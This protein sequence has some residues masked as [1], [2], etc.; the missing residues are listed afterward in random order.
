MKAKGFKM[1]KN[2][3]LL[4]YLLFFL[5]FLSGI[6]WLILHYFFAKETDFTT[7]PSPNEARTLAIHGLIAPFFIFVLGVIYPT[8]MS[9]SFKAQKNVTSGLI[10]FIFF[11]VIIISGY[12]LY[13]IANDK[14][15]EIFSLSHS[16][17]GALLLPIL[18]AHLFLGKKVY[19]KNENKK[20]V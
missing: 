10:F 4:F 2:I 1:Q 17:L 8:H 13:Y 16:F 19:N 7:I 14:I 12:L 18:V 11:I 3:K 20:Y 15:R 9:R 5:Q 6:I